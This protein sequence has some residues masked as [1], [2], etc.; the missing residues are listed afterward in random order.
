M[1][2]R[3]LAAALLILAWAIMTLWIARRAHQQRKQ[4][5]DSTP[6][7]AS[8]IAIIYASQTGT[9]HDLA[10]RTAISFGDQA[11]LVPVSTLDPSDLAQYRTALFLVSTYGE[12]D[13]PD[14]AQA[15]LEKMAALPLE[16]RPLQGLEAA[17]LGLGDRTYDNY[18][19]FGRQVEQWLRAAGARPLF[20]MVEVDRGDPQALETWRNR[21]D[22]VF[23][24]KLNIDVD[25]PS[26]RLVHRQ[27]SNPGS[28]GR[29]CHELHLTPVDQ[30]LPSWSAGDI[31]EVC[32]DDTDLRRDYSVASVPEEGVLRLLIREHYLHD[33]QPGRGSQW[34]TQTIQPGSAVR[35]RL[36][37]N[38]SFHADCERPAIF[39]G[40]GTG[41]AG[42]RA[43]LKQRINAG[44]R[45]N[46]LLYGERQ[47]HCDLHFAADLLSWENDTWLAR[48]DLAFSRDQ[49]T[50]RY[51][52]H[53]MRENAEE[54]RNWVAQGA[55]IYV[56]GSR[57]GMAA[58]TD[59]A[60]LE[61]LGTMGYADLLARNGLRRDVY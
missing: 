40:N 42:L 4:P 1:T 6:P 34:L 20:S 60:L 13:A 59:V 61:I 49:A 37:S 8:A 47:R 35:L 22:E 12:G 48:M 52:H 7:D 18:C 28:L 39:I 2:P 30:P 57:T 19:G 3:L 55:D 50:K 25:Y 54:M 29:P 14:M 5:A 53:L 56:C 33:G 36:R 38:P 23:D 51:V 43:L 15:F 9:A 32:I 31:A 21:L 45:D 58:D 24:I 16:S 46:W 44:R 10:Q 27:V 11:R 17:V 26:W 41:I